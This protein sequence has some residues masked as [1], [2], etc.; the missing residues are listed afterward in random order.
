MDHDLKNEMFESTAEKVS[1]KTAFFSL[2]NQVP[3]LFNRHSF[4][5]PACGLSWFF[6]F[7]L[8]GGVSYGQVRLVF[9]ESPTSY[10]LF[11]PT[12]YLLFIPKT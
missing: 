4:S 2:P 6:F 12:L 1:E 7:F 9:E 5:T 10:L 11:G 8:G 3:S